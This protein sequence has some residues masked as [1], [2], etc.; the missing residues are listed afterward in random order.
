MAA[1]TVILVFDIGRTKKKLLLFDECYR[2]VYEEAVHIP[3]TID[4][5]GFPCEDIYV[6]MAWI[7][8]SSKRMLLSLEFHVK[9]INFSA[10][11]ASLVY[12]DENLVP[13]LPLYNFLKPYPSS[14]SDQFYNAYGG[15]SDFSMQTASPVMGSFNSGMQLYRI[16]YEKPEVFAKVRYALHL[17]QYLSSIISGKVYSEISSLGC[18]TNLWHFSKVNYHEWVEREQLKCLFPPTLPGD[19]CITIDVGGKTLHVGIGLYD[20]SAAL[21]P[22]LAHVPHPFILL[23]TGPWC[24]SLNPSNNTSITEYELER[25]CLCYFSWQGAPVKASRL[26]AGNRLSEAIEKG[27]ADHQRIIDVVTRQLISTNLVQRANEAK[28]II[29]EGGFNRNSVYMDLMAAVFPDLDIYSSA[30]TNASALGAAV[31]L[32]KHWNKKTI[33]SDLVELKYHA[34]ATRPIDQKSI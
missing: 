19:A 25:E 20:G 18:H 24:I 17:P 30:A 13:I 11:G 26:F 29:V 31:I 5:E 21:I 27:V 12:V 28:R 8:A 6:L 4:E 3:E 7:Q 10:Y 1:Q 16:K 23:S 14:L 9:A 34:D 22:Y 32:H 15:T 2:V 33:P